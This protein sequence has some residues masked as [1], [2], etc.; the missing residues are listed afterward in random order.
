MRI[1]K[2]IVVQRNSKKSIIKFR[3]LSFH[4]ARKEKLELGLEVKTATLETQR[5]LEV[6]F[7]DQ[8]RGVS[9]CTQMRHGKR[10]QGLSFNGN[11]TLELNT[12][13]F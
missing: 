3:V 8:K 2:L 7:S 5:N 9:N 4:Q 6:V 10:K 1:K 12:N 11:S 13:V